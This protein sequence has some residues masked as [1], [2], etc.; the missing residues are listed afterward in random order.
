MLE[1]NEIIQCI[2]EWANKHKA[3][4]QEND[5]SIEELQNKIK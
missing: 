3:E 5:A 1:E 4:V 2:E